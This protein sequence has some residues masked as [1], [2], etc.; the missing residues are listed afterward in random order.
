MKSIIEIAIKMDVPTQEKIEMC[1]RNIKWCQESKQV[2]L[3][4]RLNCR[5]AYLLYLVFSKYQIGHFQDKQYRRALTLCGHLIRELAKID[6][7]SLIM[8]VH[9]TEARIYKDL[10]D[11]TRAKVFPSFPVSLLVFPHRLQNDRVLDLRR[12]SHASR[13][14][15][16]LR[17]HLREFQKSGLFRRAISAISKWRFRS[18]TK[19]STRLRS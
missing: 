14:R 2:F 11:I 17:R 7:K 19:R 3:A 4:Q 15:H 16:S 18:S 1:E 13:H 5:L 8:E 6:D 9:I 12:R 10:N